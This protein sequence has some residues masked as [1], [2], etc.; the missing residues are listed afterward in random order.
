MPKCLLLL[1]VPTEHVEQA[2]RIC[3]ISFLWEVNVTVDVAFGQLCRAFCTSLWGP[4]DCLQNSRV[5]LS[6]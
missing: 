6:S 1:M 4:E 3:F 5:L 2:P